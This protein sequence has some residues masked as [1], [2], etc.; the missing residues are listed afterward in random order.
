MGGN[1]SAEADASC[2]LIVSDFGLA[3]I[4]PFRAAHGVHR[5]NAATRSALSIA[6]L[7]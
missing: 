2:V 6:A 4:R 1:E 5:H 3:A 7:L